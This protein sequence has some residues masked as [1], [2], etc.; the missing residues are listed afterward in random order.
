MINVSTITEQIKEWFEDDANLDGFTVTRSEPVNQSPSNAVNG[1]IGI[2]RRGVDY[3]PGQLGVSPNNYEGDL[4]IDIVLQ[5]T[6][7]SSGAD[8][9]DILEQSIKY[10]LDRLVQLPK[11]YI[12]HFPEV[13]VEYAYLETDKKSMYFQGALITVLAEV[14][15]E[16]K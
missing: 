11:T 10:M 4:T 5:R 12:D 15:I 9:E 13:D 7:L 3:E 16:V 8:A 14:S 2:Y 6:S 1:W